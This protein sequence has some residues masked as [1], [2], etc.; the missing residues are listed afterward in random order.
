MSGTDANAG[1]F[2][3]KT[4]SQINDEIIV[5]KLK[6][7]IGDFVLIFAG[8]LGGFFVSIPAYYTFKV[9]GVAVFV[10]IFSL[11]AYLFRIAKKEYQKTGRTDVI[12]KMF[13]YYT[14]ES[15]LKGRERDD[16]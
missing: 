11:C 10:I 13:D 2:K 6:I 5:P 1:E 9:L 8:F 7:G 3:I 16:G 14:A 12:G 4:Y 15:K